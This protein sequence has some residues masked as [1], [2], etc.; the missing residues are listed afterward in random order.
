MSGAMPQQH[1]AASLRFSFAKEK[2]SLV[3]HRMLC[4]KKS[5]ILCICIV[6]NLRKAGVCWYE[7]VELLTHDRRGV[8]FA[9]AADG[10]G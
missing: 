7:K 4:Y 10:C 8:G 3:K 1:T 2:I 5:D 9:G 6:R